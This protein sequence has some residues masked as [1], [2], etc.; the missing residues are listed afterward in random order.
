MNSALSEIFESNRVLF[1]RRFPELAG[2]LGLDTRERSIDLLSLI[3]DTYR[4]LETSSGYPSL[5]V[6]G[7]AVHSRV[8]PRREAERAIAES[9]KFG[10]GGCLFCGLG[11]AY[12]PELY[13][14]KF[15]AAT[16]IVLEPE[17]F[18]LVSALA[19]RPLD[20]LFA[21]TNLVIAVGIPASEAAQIAERI[22]HP[23]I[24][25]HESA[26]LMSVNKAWWEEFRTVA[27]R[28]REKREINANTLKKF[29][30]LWLRNMCRNLKELRSRPGIARFENLASGIPSLVLAAGPSLDRILPCLPELRERF[31]IIAVDTAVRA[32]LR[33][34]VEPDF[35]VLVD[36]QYWNF[37][38]LDGL[39]SP[40]S[41]LITESAAW[42]AVFRFRCRKIFLC[43]SLFPLG[44][45]LEARTGW[46]GELGAGG[47]VSTTAWDFARFIGSSGIYMAGLDLGYPG[48]KTHF[49]GSLFEERTHTVSGRMSPAETA[50]MLALTA[51]GL[52]RVPDYLGRE[53]LTDKRLL[54][55]AWWF[56]SRLS[57]Y[58]DCVTTTLTPEGVRIPGFRTADA[59]EA[60]TLPPARA[61]IN[62]I[63]ETACAGD[64]EEAGLFQGALEELKGA[65]RD[66]LSL[67]RD[68]ERL[69]RKSEAG[70]GDRVLLAQLDEID[71]KILNH[72]AKEVAAMV[73]ALADG[74]TAK[75]GGCPPIEASRLFYRRLSSA[76][77]KNLELIAKFS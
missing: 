38:H 43:S 24:P 42:P 68:G 47:S 22:G 28:N 16:L 15:P 65:L 74:D 59:A 20:R 30:G 67:A 45:F 66:I 2:L 70:R 77:E 19:S 37:R 23:E 75:D 32:C 71:R 6:N 41:I 56:E 7:T 36:P 3:P 48:K 25:V 1:S 54:L 8:N 39:S 58:P 17:L 27:S 34:G 57:R 46:R 61:R 40:S 53:V 21:H 12:L 31:V 51:T 62:A 35:I 55:Y 49:T 33:S 9:E 13:S 69:C 29:G 11:L 18:V 52:F 73:F 72:P 26:P 10:D 76:A 63:I 64:S 50:G 4:I 14:V 5:A 44:K 60:I